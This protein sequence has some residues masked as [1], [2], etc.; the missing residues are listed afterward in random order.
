MNDSELIGMAVECF[1]A[2]EW[3]TS[4]LHASSPNR[5]RAIA[6]QIARNALQ[7]LRR[8]RLVRL[9]TDSQEEPA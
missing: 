1:Q 3:V 8:P 2:I 4:P 6:G 7:E 5:S 9:V